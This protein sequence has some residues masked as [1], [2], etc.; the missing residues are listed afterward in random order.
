MLQI[1]RQIRAV[2][3][4]EPFDPST[5]EGR[6]LERYRRI[7]FT[8]A[9][10]IAVRTVSVLVGL[11]TV[12]LLLSYLGKE[13]FGLWTAITTVVTWATLF[14][15]GL[16]NGLVNLIARA[17]GR[18]DTE[19]ATR[20]FSTAI[21]ALSAIAF[22][23][24]LVALVVVPLVQW[25]GFLGVRGVVD[26]ST[27]RWSVA[28]ALGVFILSLPLGAVPQL[29]SGY[30]KTYVT[31]AFALLGSLVGLGVLVAAVRLEAP[32]PL[33]VLALSS[34]GLL[35]SATALAY[36]RKAI[37]WVK[38]RTRHATRTA[39]RALTERSVPM[40]LY[41]IGAL[42]VNETQVLILAR[43]AGL[44]TVTD[45]AVALRLYLVVV[46]VIQLGTSSFIPPFREAQE[47]GD[48]GW[49]TRAFRHLQRVRLAMA[50]GGG[51]GLLLLGNPLLRLWLRRSDIAFGWELWAALT[52]LLVATVWVTVYVEFLW[53][54]DRVWPI[55]GLV[56]LNGIST[57]GITW[58]LAPS[59]GVLGAV[60][61]SSA[62]TVLASSWA[63][64]LMARR[65][66]VSYGEAS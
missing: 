61:A 18:E 14:D 6:S 39:L 33:L 3:R 9:S 37:P 36:A 59:H 32:L 65:L 17:H 24:S 8:T 51:A 7:V 13:R 22:T 57:V 52:V 64:P 58:A 50:F 44:S 34:T 45:Y 26:E 43:R 38:V 12:P 35:T 63:L 41:Q 48:K 47:R 16:S 15:F 31:N 30:Q 40:F 53:I 21:L 62:F 28:A 1:L 19:E 27:V 5:P 60:L 49:A 11:V 66:L 54:M 42:A 29:Y 10:A 55:V 2:T 20:L 4:L 25:S 46:S 23:L 56:V